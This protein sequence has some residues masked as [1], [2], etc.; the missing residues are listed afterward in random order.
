MND[1][2]YVL[3]ESFFNEHGWNPSEELHCIIAESPSEAKITE[4]K[5]NVETLGERA[6]IQKYQVV[7]EN[8][9]NRFILM[10]YEDEI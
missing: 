3:F 9:F 6:V 2:K 5:K 8:G 4:L 10:E 1:V 7:R